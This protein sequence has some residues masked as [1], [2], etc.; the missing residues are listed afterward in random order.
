MT[1]TT[2]DYYPNI[3]MQSYLDFSR[4]HYFD[5]NHCQD[6]MTM[7]MTLG[8]YMTINYEYTIYNHV[9]YN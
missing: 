9:E 3:I 4:C 1:R 2:C 8:N 6:Y 5:Y 7:N